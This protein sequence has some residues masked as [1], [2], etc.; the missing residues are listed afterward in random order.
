M[1]VKTPKLAIGVAVAAVIASGVG[2]AV[3]VETSAAS[4]PTHTLKFN[5]IELRSHNTSKTTFTSAEV[6]RHKGKFVGYDVV[7]GRFNPSTNRVHINVAV[8]RKGGLL[9]AQLSAK[10]NNDLHGTVTGGTGKFD[11]AVGTVTAHSVS[12]KK[13]AVTVKYHR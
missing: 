1:N 7:T 9:F 11:G 6:E 3:T 12:N 5:A 8:A 4:A 2:V 10:G 13:T